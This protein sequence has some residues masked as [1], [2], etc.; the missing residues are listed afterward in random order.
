MAMVQTGAT[1]SADYR[2]FW[3]SSDYTPGDSYKFYRTSEVRPCADRTGG[4]RYFPDNPGR[5]SAAGADRFAREPA[6]A[7][8]EAGFATGS[9]GVDF[10]LAAYHATWADGNEDEIVA[11]VSNIDAV[12]AAMVA[13]RPQEKDLLII[14]DFNLVPAIL[15]GAV[16]AADRTEGAG[17]TLNSLGVRT[18]NLYDHLLVHDAA[19]SSEIEGNAVVLDEI[20]LASTPKVY[21]QTVSDHLPISVG[22][23][24]AGP[25]D[26]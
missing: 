23:H 5:G 10:L 16:A 17:S 24:S 8:F 2:G 22:L 21:Y 4:L 12:F 20:G 18:A 19:S 13:A 25:D 3:E 1:L 6:I 14:G 15:H 7:C 11:E 9:P 26:D